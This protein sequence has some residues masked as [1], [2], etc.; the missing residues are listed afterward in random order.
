[1]TTSKLTYAELGAKPPT[2]TKRIYAWRDLINATKPAR[3]VVENEGQAP[4]TITV[5][6]RKRQVLEGLMTNPLMAA[7][8]CRISDNVL[9]LRRDYGVQITSTIYQ[10]D[11]ETGREIFGVY[12][13]DSK[14]RRID[15]GAS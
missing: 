9:P 12:T 6:R 4:R 7:S 10:T 8:Y 13:L 5:S 2:N 14:V 15:G 3:Y 11:A 1:M